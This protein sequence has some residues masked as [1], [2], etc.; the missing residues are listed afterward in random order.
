MLSSKFISC[1]EDKKG[2]KIFSEASPCSSFLSLLNFSNYTN[3]R[4]SNSES[5]SKEGNALDGICE[6]GNNLLTSANVFV[7]LKYIFIIAIAEEAH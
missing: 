6:E 3:Q 4:L 5:V 7:Y 2:R 1:I